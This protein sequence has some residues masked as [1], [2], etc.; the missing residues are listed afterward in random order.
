M[1]SDYFEQVSEAA[2][3]L[4]SRLRGPAPRLGIV[5]V[6][7]LGAVADAVTEPAVASY[8]DIPHF[9]Q[10]T[11][12]GHTGRIGAGDLD[13]VPVIVM[14]GRVHSYEGYAPAQVTFPMRVL[15]ALGVRTVVL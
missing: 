7:W 10:S 5:L 14:Q 1:S 11:V 8:S 15:G 4:R 6:S 9:P 2:A 12:A 3:W 13:S